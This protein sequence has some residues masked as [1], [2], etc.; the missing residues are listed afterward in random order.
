MNRLQ[1]ITFFFFFWRIKLSSPGEARFPLGI[2]FWSGAPD[3]PDSLSLSTRKSHHSVNF[4]AKLGPSG[5]VLGSQR[6]QYIHGAEK[7]VWY[8]PQ[9]GDLT[10]QR[11]CAKS[12][13]GLTNRFERWPDLADLDWLGR[14]DG[15][16]T[17]FGMELDRLG[18]RKLSKTYQLVEFSSISDTRT[19]MFRNHQSN[20]M[21]FDRIHNHFLKSMPS[22]MF[23]PGLGSAGSF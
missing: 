13:L 18:A 15:F 20:Q 6:P 4:S 2:P 7:K 1:K 14:R 5:H 8:A 3:S 21:K 9:V 10:V 12:R 11:A 22:E 19:K 17:S 23:S 16:W